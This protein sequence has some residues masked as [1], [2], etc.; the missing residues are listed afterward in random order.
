MRILTEYLNVKTRGEGQILDITKDVQM[1][2]QKSGLRNGVVTVF[3][4]G[5]TGAITT[6][7]YESGLLVDF[8]AML[9]RIAPKNVSYEHE[10]MWH[11]GNGH[12]HVRSS[13]IGPSLTVPLVDGKLTVGTWQQIV[14][15]ELDNRPRT[16]KL[17]LQMMGE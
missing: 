1:T 10:K 3:M 6:I 16:R 9:E 11:D 4:P 2:V 5:S 17:V 13:L 15:V 7:E 14:L 8:P 12:S